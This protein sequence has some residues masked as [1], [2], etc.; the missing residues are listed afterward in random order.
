MHLLEAIEGFRFERLYLTR[1]MSPLAAVASLPTVA[2]RARRCDLV[3]VHGDAA[4][5]VCLPL[6]GL[7]P[8][9]LTTHGLHLL[10]RSDGVSS[11]LARRG[12]SAAI[13]RSTATICNSRVELDELGS[14]VRDERK[15]RLIPN[16]VAIPQVRSSDVERTAHRQRLGI[17]RSD[18]A[19]LWAGS[20]DRR[21]DP[22][23]F[24]NA[25]ALA[26]R[27]LV[28]LVAGDG[29]LRA[30][31]E[32][33]ADQSIRVLG[34]CDDLGRVMS[35]CDAFALTSEREGLALTILEA[36][37]HELPVIVSDTA[38]NLEA[39]G[40]AGISFPFGNP[41]ALATALR[42][43]EASS[44]LRVELGVRARRRVERFYRASRMVEATRQLYEMVLDR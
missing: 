21:K 20:L 29:P 2:R 30:E 15:L 38:E 17:N 27:P 18:V 13:A 11:V 16:G 1:S 19:V 31:V 41:S 6:L 24:L 14:I 7:R 26:G 34:Q 8:T 36:M 43:L 39:I 5:I 12:I 10:R 3:Q 37:A 23:T 44:E 9:L 25:I 35:V 40:D 28:G 4:S 33:R 42:R 32:H 22:L